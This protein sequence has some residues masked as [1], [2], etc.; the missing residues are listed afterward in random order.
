MRRGIPIEQYPIKGLVSPGIQ[1]SGGYG[2]WEA[3][4]AAGLDLWQWENGGYPIAFKCRV[5][6]WHRLHSLVQLHTADAVRP[7]DSK[8]GGGKKPKRRPSRRR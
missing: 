4:R 8:P 2:E 1:Y 6:A 7:R 3:C 5:M